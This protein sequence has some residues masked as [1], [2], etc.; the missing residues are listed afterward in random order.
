MD[1]TDFSAEQLIDDN[2]GTGRILNVEIAS[3]SRGYIVTGEGFVSTSLDQFNPVTGQI[4]ALGIAGLSD[5]D[6]RDLAIGPNGNLWVAVADPVSP[7]VVII[8]PVD[9]SIVSDGIP[10]T[11]N[12][13]SL[14]F[15]Q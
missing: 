8:N 6:I 9:N 14:A 11:Q 5:V 15:T 3:A 7:R 12:P 1:T 2:D 13:T 10:T 4:E